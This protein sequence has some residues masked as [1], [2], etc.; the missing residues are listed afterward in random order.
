MYIVPMRIH[1][2]SA[3]QG[4]HHEQYSPFQSAM[5][6][7]LDTPYIRLWTP[8]IRLWTPPDLQAENGTCKLDSCVRIFDLV[9]G[10][11]PQA[12]MS[13]APLLLIDLTASLCPG[14][15]QVAQFIGVCRRSKLVSI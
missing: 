15:S 9:L 1:V 11:D 10:S 7:R 6:K 13:Y 2:Q 14:Y 8:H 12:L 3:S 4:G 5:C